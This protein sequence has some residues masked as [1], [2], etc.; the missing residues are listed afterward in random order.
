MRSRRKELGRFPFLII[1][2]R[3]DI[4]RIIYEVFP[5]I[6]MQTADK[7]DDRFDRITIF[8]A[9]PRFIHDTRGY[10]TLSDVSMHPEGT[11]RGRGR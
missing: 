7:L 2:R 3:N 6:R 1:S 4:S 10:L 9:R 8:M 5:S 11:L